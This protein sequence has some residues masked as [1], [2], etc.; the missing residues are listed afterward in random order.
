MRQLGHSKPQILTI[1][2]YLSESAALHEWWAGPATDCI[3]AGHCNSQCFIVSQFGNYI[4][5]TEKISV[6]HAQNHITTEPS[7]GASMIFVCLPA[8]PH[9][10]TPGLETEKTQQMSNGYSRTVLPHTDIQRMMFSW[11]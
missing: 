5:D 11:P 2:D 4:D 7:L 8:I 10:I 3:A 6:I 1:K 9:R